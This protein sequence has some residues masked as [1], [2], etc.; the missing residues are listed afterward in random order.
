VTVIFSPGAYVDLSVVRT[1]DAASTP[2]IPTTAVVFTVESANVAAFP[3]V[4]VTEDAVVA[5]AAVTVN[6]AVPIALA[7]I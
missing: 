2:P 4:I 1:T 6:P 5:A 3:N 7:D